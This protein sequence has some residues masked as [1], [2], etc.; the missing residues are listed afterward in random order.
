MSNAE[1]SRF[2][3]LFR[4]VASLEKRLNRLEDSH[5]QLDNVVDPQGWIG[6]AFKLQEEDLETI[7]ADIKTLD[8]KLDI[9]LSHLTGINKNL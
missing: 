1:S 5:Q 2:Y 4:K 3:D 9:I 7:K 8:S 6:E